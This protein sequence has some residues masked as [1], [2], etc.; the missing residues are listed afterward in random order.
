L[1]AKEGRKYRLPTE[2]EWEYACRSGAQT[3]YPWGDNPDDGKGWANGCDETAKEQF[4]L[5]PSFNWSDGYLYTSP[6][7]TFKPNAWGIYDPLGNALQ[8]CGDR[9]GDYPA[10]AA[11]NPAG[12]LTGQNRVL[13]GGAFIYG[14]ARTRLAFRG[15]NLPDFR[16]FYI[17]F[18]ILLE[19]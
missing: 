1:S 14:P 17:G 12:A 13:R 19:D 6:V 7:A 2:A 5:F 16:N 11:T 8:W 18:R 3:A 15:R 9:F 4:T 10:G